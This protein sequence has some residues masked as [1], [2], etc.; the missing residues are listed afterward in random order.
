[1]LERSSVSGESGL[2]TKEGKSVQSNFSSTPHPQLGESSPATPHFYSST[3]SSSSSAAGDFSPASRGPYSKSAAA[4][5]L[6][7]AAVVG[8]RDVNSPD[9][10]RQRLRWIRKVRNIKSETATTSSRLRRNSASSG[11]GSSSRQRRQRTRSA[12]ES[13]SSK[14]GQHK[15]AVELV[16]DRT[17]MMALE[18]ALTGKDLARIGCECVR[19]LESFRPTEVLQRGQ[20][21]VVVREGSNLPPK[22]GTTY[23]RVTV[24]KQ[25][26]QKTHI[27]TKCRTPKWNDRLLYSLP[28]TDGQETSGQPRTICFELIR[29]HDVLAD[30]GCA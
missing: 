24:D 16:L 25:Q 26:C 14:M 1:V 20:L 3:T 5:S 12:G 6:T 7:A 11:G 29:H 4:G 17:S 9:H 22:V 8:K 23:V 2:S 28:R 13:D 10:R 15:R 18:V 27:I 21:V 19:S 30:E